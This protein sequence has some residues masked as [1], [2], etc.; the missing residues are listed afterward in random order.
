MARRALLI[1]LLLLT[2][3]APAT[4]RELIIQR[5]E[6]EIHVFPDGSIEV[7]ETIQPRFI[8]SWNG[9]FRTIPVEDNYRGFN[10]TLFLEPLAVTDE[11]G[12]PL[13]HEIS[14]E[15]HYR[16]FKIWVPGARDAVRTVV[17][18]YRVPNALLFFEE[19]DE[20]YWDITGDEWE[21]PIEAAT[22]RILLPAGAT[23]VRAIAY[24][25]AYGSREQDADVTITGN[26]VRYRMRRGLNFREGLTAVVGWDKG[27]VRE[28][29]AA[30]KASL[31]LRSNWPLFL[32][33]LVFA[34]MF[35]LW[36]KAGR[37]PRLRPIAAQ[38]A[39]PEDLTPAEVGTLTD[40]SPDMRDI[41]ATLVD[42]AVRGYVLI[43]EKEEKKLLGLFSDKDY[44]FTLRK[45]RS[46]WKEVKPHEAALLGGVFFPGYSPLYSPSSLP[47]VELSDLENKF[48]K[49]L[50]GI[51]DHIFDALMARGYY[52]NRPDK[53]KRNYV[54]A[55]VVVVFLAIWGGGFIAGILG[56]QSFPFIV[57][58]VL[59]GGIIAGFG[60]V[61]PARTVRG[62][63]TLE[64]VLGFEEFLG[65]VESDRFARVVKTP[66][67]FEKFLPYAMALGVEKNWVRAFEDIYR[68]P[69]EWYRGPSGHT[70][71]PRSFVSDL[72]R[73]STRA[74][75][76]MASSPRSSGGSGFGG[77]GGSGGGGGGGGGGGF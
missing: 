41:T 73:M 75:A 77:G 53:V 14:R 26:E 57:A 19:H 6:V 16:K 27:V 2:A 44:V 29:G 17:L 21:V 76:A 3:A 24:T 55:G 4:A 28:P 70:F 22:A 67:M 63:H 49:D 59:S 20:L 13:K 50:P 46:E 30:E 42:L 12:Q 62:S 36:Y 37:D 25:G 34:V 23:G 15:R 48:Y 54:I 51:R 64:G 74:A 43:E 1:L 40:N 8:G 9:I 71:Q 10:R 32:P 58:A 60:L 61:M 38:Y 47:S 52:T 69:P 45:L 66:E 33:L 11:R 5:F 18:R 56:Q 65:R 39:P 72:G 35:W 68:R 31:F 7:S